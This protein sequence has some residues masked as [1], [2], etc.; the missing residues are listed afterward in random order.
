MTACPRKVRGI[1]AVGLIS[2][3]TTAL[4]AALMATTIVRPL[5]RLQR[6]TETV[7]GGDF[8]SRAVIDEGA[9][10]SVV[11]RTRSTR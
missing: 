9:Q 6:A 1:L 11:W 10:E 2:L 5:R 7:A 8:A 3:G 4:A